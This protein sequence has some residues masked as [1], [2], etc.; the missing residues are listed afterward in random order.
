MQALLVVSDLPGV[1]IRVHTCPQTDW[2]TASSYITIRNQ[3]SALRN[4][5]TLVRRK[6]LKIFEGPVKVTISSNAKAPE[7]V[8][9]YY[10]RLGD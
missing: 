6:A 3:A 2:V 1:W 8:R 4:R 7:F 5:K 10:E 9:L